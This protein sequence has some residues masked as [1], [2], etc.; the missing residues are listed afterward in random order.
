MEGFIKLVEEARKAC[1]DP[2]DPACVEQRTPDVLGYHDGGDI[3]NA[4]DPENT[5]PAATS[6]LRASIC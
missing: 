1:H 2:D 4:M 3:P 5:R 6:I